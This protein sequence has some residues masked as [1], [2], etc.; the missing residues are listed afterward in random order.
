MN[1]LANTVWITLI[2]TLIALFVRSRGWPI[3]LPLL[4]SG[5]LIGLLPWG[6]SAPQQPELTAVL[7]LAPLV[8]GEALSSS[9]VDIKSVR[10]P[11]LALAI[12]L[13][14]IS[15]VAIGGLTALLI[16]GIPLALA[17]ALGAILAPTDLVV[18]A[19]SARRA[20]LPPR[21][22][23]I[24]EGESLLNDGTGLTALK[25]AIMAAVAGTVTATEAAVLLAQTVTVGFGLGFLGG[26]LLVLLLRKGSDPIGHGAV[27][28]A[29]P[30]PLY[31]VT[32]A[33]G[34]SGILALVLAGLMASHA[35]YGDPDYQGRLEV[36]SLWRQITA[37]LQAIA[38]LV[39]GLELPGLLVGLPASQRNTLLWAV[40]VIVAGLIAVRMA[41]VLAGFG[42]GRLAGVDSPVGWRGATLIGWA[43]TRGP[44][45][46]L[47]AFSLPLLTVDGVPLAYR[48]MV[49]AAALMAITVTLLVST[50]LVPVARLLRV[51]SGSDAAVQ[52]RLRRSMAEAALSTLD[53]AARDAALRGEP[54]PEHVITALR[55][56]T[57]HR[58][59]MTRR[60][61]AAQRDQRRV[62]ALQLAMLEAEQDELVRL[63][64]AEELPD[65]AIR[66]LLAELDGRIALARS[67]GAI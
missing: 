35:A 24:L 48:D 44:V 50:T 21:L 23:N 26:W 38:F 31:V 33:A 36:T 32:E 10:R 9:Y 54:F 39:L 67:T 53:A 65:T 3:A 18:V 40:P 56:A 61:E 51:Q 37:M 11:V 13:V 25:V 29:A 47:A 2:A 7:V 52:R 19:A 30:L 22:V 12:G 1:P 60:R 20:H 34:G 27:L 58:I 28:L 49:V 43:G 42:L 5:L 16:S 46:A 15:T 63:R 62:R 6:P 17:L 4:G 64:D 45:S 41:A 14:I 8:F 59:G 57:D 66:P 55:A